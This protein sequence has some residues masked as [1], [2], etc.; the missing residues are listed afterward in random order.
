M[1]TTTSK[2]DDVGQ[3][4][5]QQRVDE[6]EKKGYEGHV[7]DETPNEAYSLE[8]KGFDDTP[9]VKRGQDVKKAREAAKK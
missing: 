3:A 7:A 2:G 8:S 5:V 6:A 9:E 1:A 4:E